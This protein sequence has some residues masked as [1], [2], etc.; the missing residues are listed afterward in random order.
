MRARRDRSEP[1]IS[2]QWTDET[3]L[4]GRRSKDLPAGP[5]EPAL[6]QIGRYLA[7]PVGHLERCRERYGP[8]F[9]LRW[10]GRPPTVYFTELSAIREIFAAPTDVLR[11]GESNAVLDFIAGPRSVARLDGD[12]HKQRRRALVTPFMRLESYAAVM[13]DHT[14]DVL[15]AA[16]PRPVDFRSLSQ[17]LSLQ[18]LITC[19][20]GVHEPRAARH[21]HDLIVT[22]I[23]DSLNPVMAMAWVALPGVALRKRLVRH[24]GPLAGRRV[25]G[26]LPFV[27][28]ATTI[29]QL[30]HHLHNLIQ[31]ARQ[32]SENDPQGD[33]LSLLIDHAAHLPDDDLRDEMM[34]LLVA[35]HET[36]STTMDWFFVEVLRRPAVYDRLRAEID[37]VVG[38]DV[39]TAAHLSRLPYLRATIQE[40]LRLRAPV[41]AIG[42]YVGSD[43]QIA[44]VSLREGLVASL[45]ISGLQRDPAVWVD[46]E[47]FNPDRFMDGSS[48]RTAQIPFGGGARSCVGKHFALFQ[49]QVVLATMLAR[50]TF[51]PGQWPVSRQ[52]QRGLFTGVSHPVDLTIAERR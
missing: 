52:V 41:P 38:T 40:C 35:G 2:S 49:L 28:L 10:P 26:R 6:I 1:S 34:A 32:A 24:L 3:G 33:V 47:R 7:D 16:G 25:I 50:F 36:T 12:D 45:S 20:L 31:Q 42:R 46:P 21:L 23:H 18:N 43:T 19:A 29:D 5:R 37:D 44:G 15:R 11:A 13:S 48:D 8:V 17:S 14:V 27:R 39:V 51:T 30:D 4:R 22:Y 9:T